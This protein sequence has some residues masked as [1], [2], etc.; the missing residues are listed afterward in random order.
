MNVSGSLDERLRF[1]IANKRLIEVTYGGRVRVAEPHDYGIKNGTPKVLLLQLGERG[2]AAKRSESTGWR[3]LDVAK[4][5]SCQVLERTFRGS[6]GPAYQQH[7]T[8]DRVLARV[9]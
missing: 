3:L 7:M 6:R 1:A 2:D 9:E 4:I 5:G 8:W